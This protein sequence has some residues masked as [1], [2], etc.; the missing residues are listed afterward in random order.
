MEELK[1]QIQVVI[2]ARERARETNALR[3]AS[4][5][6]WVEANQQL[7]DRESIAKSVCLETE[8]IL[9]EFALQAYAETGDKAVAPGIG[10]RI[11]SRLGYDSKEAMGW[12]MEHKLALKLDASAFEKIAKMSNLPFVTTTEEPQATIA[13]QLKEAQEVK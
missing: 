8:A 10:I 9:R 6:Q 7:L 3:V 5:N 13:T 11:M 12:A 2:E 4:Y 1:E